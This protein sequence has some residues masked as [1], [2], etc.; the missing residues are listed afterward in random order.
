MKAGH[1][2]EQIIIKKIFVREATTETLI[3]LEQDELVIVL[4]NRIKK[5]FEASGL[6]VILV[7]IEIFP[8]MVIACPLKS[9][10]RAS[11]LVLSRRVLKPNE[12]PNSNHQP[13][14]STLRFRL[15]H[16]VA[17][18]KKSRENS[19]SM[20]SVVIS[21]F[22]SFHSKK[23]GKNRSLQNRAKHREIV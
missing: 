20:T 17:K 2:S 9:N 7:L 6:S 15:Q 11:E 23:E 16:Q 8:A 13:A 14:S 3:E 1:R 5:Q 21:V 12:Q 4:E 22:I 19:A 18:Q 10:F